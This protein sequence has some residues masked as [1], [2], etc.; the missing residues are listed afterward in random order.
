MS[1]YKIYFVLIL[2]EWDKTQE[3]K[4]LDASEFY[5]SKKIFTTIFRPKFINR[6]ISPHF[7]MM[8]IFKYL[9]CVKINI[10]PTLLYSEIKVTQ[11][12]HN[13]VKG[14]GYLESSPLRRR[15]DFSEK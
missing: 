12:L 3:R 14:L 13:T 15:L 2:N 11:I 7:T 6:S 5:Y 9:S 8:E 10:Q 1:F 4:T